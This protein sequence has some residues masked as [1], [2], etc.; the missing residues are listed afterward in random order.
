[1]SRC[2]VA[3]S[4]VFTNINTGK[5]KFGIVYFAQEAITSKAVAI[6]FIPKQI[7]YENKCLKRIQQVKSSLRPLY[8]VLMPQEMDVLNMISHPFIIRVFGF[9]DVRFC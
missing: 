2:V 4:E 8:S 9:Y 3:D 5:G 1:M 6:K 7:I